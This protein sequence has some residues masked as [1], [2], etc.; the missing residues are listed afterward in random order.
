MRRNAKPLLDRVEIDAKQVRNDV[1]DMLSGAKCKS[2]GALALARRREKEFVIVAVKCLNSC[3]VEFGG[4]IGASGLL[5]SGN[6]CRITRGP[7]VAEPRPTVIVAFCF[8]KARLSLCP[9]GQWELAP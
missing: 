8:Y 4:K 9:T 3:P 1:T 6:D 2:F 7:H 5:E